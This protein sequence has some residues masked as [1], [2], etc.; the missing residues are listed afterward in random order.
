[1]VVR[2]AAVLADGEVVDGDDLPLEA[3]D[4]DWRPEAGFAGT[5]AE[6]EQQYIQTMLER[7]DG[8]RGRTAKALGIDVKTLY[9]KLGPQKGARSR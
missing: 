8:H 1:M 4:E 2:R 9:N 6:V 3:R 5:L 7:H